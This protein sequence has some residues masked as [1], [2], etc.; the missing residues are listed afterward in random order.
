MKRRMISLEPSK[1]VLMRQSRR[2]RSTATGCLAARGQGLRGFVAA[3]AADLHG[4]IDDLPGALGGPELAEGGFE[5]HVGV[6]VAV[7]E[8]RG[9]ED[10]RFH[11]EGLRG[12]AGDFLGDGARVCR[13]ARPIARGREPIARATRR[14]RF[15]RPVQAA[16][17]V[18]RPVLSVVSATRRPLPSASRI[19]SR[20]TRTS[21]KRI[22]AL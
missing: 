16:G 5:A 3:P 10:H 22:T 14:Q 8:A 11:R 9:V 1:I 15:A 6:L 4:L 7:H 13:L 20:G 18:S 2:K 21:V 17:S 12:H 19:F